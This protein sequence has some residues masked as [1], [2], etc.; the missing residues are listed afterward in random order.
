MI[1]WDDHNFPLLNGPSKGSQ[2]GWGGFA[3]TRRRNCLIWKSVGQWPNW[4]SQIM[5]YHP[6]TF[7]MLGFHVI[8]WSPNMANSRQSGTC[9]SELVLRINCTIN[10]SPPFPAFCFLGQ[11][12]GRV[13]YRDSKLSGGLRFGREA[14]QRGN[15][16]QVI[17][18]D[19]GILYLEPNW[20]LILKGPNP[21]KQGRNSNQNSRV[22]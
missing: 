17:R 13:P 5:I 4:R 21:P 11:G 18:S 15:R 6:Q 10:S 9:A 22:I 14:C 2:L 7:R 16:N 12:S 8:M 1:I 20:P 3:P 19:H